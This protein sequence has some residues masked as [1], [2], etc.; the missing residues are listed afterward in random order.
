M[1]QRVEGTKRKDPQ[2]VLD[3]GFNWRDL[4][5]EDGPWLE[6]GEIITSSTWTITADDEDANTTPLVADSTDDDGERTIVWLSG[7]TAGVSYIVT[8][9]IETDG[10]RKED[11]SFCIVV[12]HR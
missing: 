10:D 9:S 6:S 7:G 11:R 4:E 8:N 3:Y 12:T 2:A 1:T 5:D